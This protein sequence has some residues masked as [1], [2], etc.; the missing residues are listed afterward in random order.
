[1]SRFEEA[2]IGVEGDNSKVLDMDE[3]KEAQEVANEILAYRKVQGKGFPI[4]NTSFGV[5]FLCIAA[6]TK[7]IDVTRVREITLPFTKVKFVRCDFF[8]RN[9]FQIAIAHNEHV[10]GTSYPQ[11]KMKGDFTWYPKSNEWETLGGLKDKEYSNGFRDLVT[12][13]GRGLI[14]DLSTS[15]YEITLSDSFVLTFSRC[16]DITN[17]LFHTLAVLD[18]WSLDMVAANTKTKKHQTRLYVNLQEC[19]IAIHFTDESL[20]PRE[21]RKPATGPE[22]QLIVTEIRKRGYDEGREFARVP[23]FIQK[24][25]TRID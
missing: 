1:M 9:L 8:H 11:K 4:Y 17:D 24:K 23:D 6:D 7:M 12:K 13:L 5:F 18:K 3:T 25:Y 10:G 15:G 14:P 22:G 2:K 16:N 21:V 20:E 19:S